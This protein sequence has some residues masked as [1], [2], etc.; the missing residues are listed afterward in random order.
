MKLP[1]LAKFLLSGLAL[2]VAP[3][4]V[5]D[6]VVTKSGARLLGT[7]KKIDGSK[8]VLATDYAGDISIK[9]SEV[10]SIDTAEVIT[11]RLAGG[12]TMA[13]TIS[14]TPEGQV[15]ITGSD[16]TIT[17]SV[18]KVAMTWAPGQPDPSIE[19]DR[20][21]WSYEVAVDIT[22]KNGNSEQLGTAAGARATLAGPTDK[23]QFYTAYN[24]QETDNVKSADQFKAGI[25]YANTFSGRYSWYV[26]NEGGFDRVK[27]IELY[28]VAAAGLGYA[29]IDKKKQK[30]T[31]R[32]G[33]S[34]RYEGYETAGVEDVSSAGL[35]LSLL[36]TLE[37]ENGR[38]QNAFTFVPAF[39]DFGNYR[40]LHDSFFEMPI[41]A[42]LWKLRIGLNND[43]TSQPSPGREK[44]DTTYY[45]RF[46]LNWGE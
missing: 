44:M 15:A 22:G 45:T 31:G 3:L 26:R 41:L 10:V 9:Q 18:D 12:T 42:S 21:K 27:D 6:V 11:V 19:E 23:L 35:D 13:G 43:Y 2:A 37:F 46:V 14:T 4:A 39:D 1:I 32:A 16:G 38:M 7:V 30:L 40:A 25:D 36:H 5:G 24:R 20:R 17:T 33:L 29:L 34:Y 28:N 8:V